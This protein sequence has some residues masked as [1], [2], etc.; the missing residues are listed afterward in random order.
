MPEQSVRVADQ[1]VE[2][3][4]SGLC[5]VP[6]DRGFTRIV[7]VMGGAVGGDHLTGARHLAA[8]PADRADQLGD[9]VLGGD[10][11]VEDRGIQ[12]TPGLAGQRPGRDDDGLDCLEDPVRGLRGRQPAPPIRQRRGMK[13]AIGHRESARGLPPQIEGHRIHGFAVGQAVQR[14]QG[15]HRSHHIG[16]HTRAASTAGKQITKH[17]IGEQLPAMSGQKPEHTARLEQMTRH[18]LRIKN[19]SLII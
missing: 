16:G 7:I 9:G 14:L 13:G 19:F 17:L 4:L 15:D 5:V 2:Q 6:G 18:R 10:R 8:D 1:R 11:I 12:R 3:H